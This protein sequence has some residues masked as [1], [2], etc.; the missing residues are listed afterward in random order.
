MHVLILMRIPFRIRMLDHPAGRLR[1]L[2]QPRTIAL[3]Q[4]I[5]DLHARTRR[6]AGL[7]PEFNLGVRLIAIDGDASDTHFHGADI[8]SAHAVEVL[9]DA[10]A[11]GVVVALLFLAS[12][13]NE[14]RG[15]E[16]QGQAYALHARI[17]SNSSEMIHSSILRGSKSVWNY[18]Q[19][20]RRMPVASKI[21]LPPKSGFYLGKILPQRLGGQFLFPSRHDHGGDGISDHV[22]RRTGHA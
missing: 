1:F 18:G 5:A 4:V 7:W 20:M 19:I 14:N 2:N 13:R 11:N 12:A 22:H 17:Y 3:L 21:A 15:E 16:S 6:R 10:S 9:R 8:K